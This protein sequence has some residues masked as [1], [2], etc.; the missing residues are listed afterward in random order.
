M[1]YLR[2]V[3]MMVGVE[4]NRAEE[5]ESVARKAHSIG[6]YHGLEIEQLVTIEPEHAVAI[7]INGVRE[8][9]AEIHCPP[10]TC[11][12]QARIVVRLNHR[13]LGYP[14]WGFVSDW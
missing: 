3:L 11:L 1:F 13:R 10:L 4:R 9:R 14:V 5:N 2:S 12:G 8:T 7:R 6:S